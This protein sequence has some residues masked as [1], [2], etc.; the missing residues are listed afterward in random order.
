ML[1]IAKSN[2]E[3]SNNSAR[4]AAV[5]LIISIARLAAAALAIPI[6]A[7]LL[8]LITLAIPIIAAPFKRNACKAIGGRAASSAS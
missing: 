2:S 8:K 4:L 5:A 6:T 7:A 1:E 3:I